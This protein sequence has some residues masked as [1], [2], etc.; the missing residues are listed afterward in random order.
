MG[1]EEGRKGRERREG[2]RD[3]DQTTKPPP[4][5][6]QKMQAHPVLPAF[7]RLKQDNHHEF[8][9]SLG[10]IVSSSLATEKQ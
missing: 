1:G 10:Y 6:P 5:P 3:Q 4:P 9:A 2:E 7:I 8:E